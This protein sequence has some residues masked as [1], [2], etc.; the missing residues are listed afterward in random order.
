[1]VKSFFIS[2]AIFMGLLVLFTS[3]VSG[4]SDSTTD[5]KGKMNQII[6]LQTKT[7]QKLFAQ[8]QKIGA[9]GKKK[10]QITGDLE[11]L[12]RQ[13]AGLQSSIVQ[14]ETAYAQKKE[15]FKQLLRSYQRM[16][17]GS[18]LDIILE[19][20]DLTD[21]LRRL[22]ILRDITRNTGKL[23]EQL[24]KS[25]EK[26][27]AD[28]TKLEDE[29]TMLRGKQI[30]FDELLA[31]ENQLKKDLEDYYAS[32]SAE[33]E[34]YQK[35]LTDLQNNW[36]ELKSLLSNAVKEF[37][38]LIE[39]GN[40]PPDFF[41]LTGNF[42]SIKGSIADKAFNEII[43]GNPVFPQ[44]ILSFE[45]GNVEMRIP[46]RNLVLEGIF[47]VCEGNVLKLEVIEGSFY[48]IPLEK[49]AVQEL[50]QDGD[51][52]INFDSLLGGY[53]L[54]TVQTLNGYLEFSISPE[55]PGRGQQE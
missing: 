25:K 52:A 51:L 44:I 10:E 23:I 42:L 12:N 3:Q 32:L 16:G 6:N 28:K 17:P 45:Q 41:K 33:R 36:N 35:Y 50:F 2:S 18:Y 37:F 55:I 8:E 43:A 48:G 53:T 47:I 9:M 38:S 22:N 13:I 29:L 39:E 31:K 14:E 27:V 1:M 5:S 40:L 19:S 4:Q 20:D 15:D 24:Q 26:Q 54:N 21:F 7:L 34:N 46:D 30:Q 11:T 49:E